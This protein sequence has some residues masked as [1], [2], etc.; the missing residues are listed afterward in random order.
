[1]KIY[2]LVYTYVCIEKV[3]NKLK[4]L[5]QIEHSLCQISIY[6]KAIKFKKIENKGLIC[7]IPNNNILLQ[8]QNNFKIWDRQC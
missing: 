2:A 3:F 8:F 6:S 7:T 4:Y 5:R 1:M